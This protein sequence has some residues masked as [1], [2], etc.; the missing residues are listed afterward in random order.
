ME[1]KVLTKK[2]HKKMTF[3]NGFLIVWL[4]TYIGV[5]GEYQEFKAQFQSNLQP[6]IS[7]T[8]RNINE[9]LCYFEDK[10]GPIQFVSTIDDALVLISNERDKK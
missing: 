6:V 2:I 8:P 1:G 10:I 5:V 3:G 9:L 4:D 7:M